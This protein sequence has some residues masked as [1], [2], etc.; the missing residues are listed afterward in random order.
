MKIVADENIALLGH[1]FGFLGTIIQ[2]AGRDI[3]A[4]DVRDADILLVRSVTKVDAAL[5]KNSTVKFVGSVTTGIDHLDVDWLNQANIVWKNA[6][7]CNANAVVEYII[8]VVASLQKEG[9]LL[10]DHLRAGIVGAG[11]IGSSVAEKLKM[12]GF[13]IVLCD[14]LQKNIVHTPFEHLEALD[15]ISFHTPFIQTGDYP[16]FHLV[17]KSFLQKQ[18]KD[19]VLVNTGRGAVFHSHDLKYYGREC[20]WCLD[21]WEN[22]PFIDFSLLEEA[23]IATPHI[24]GYSV[25]AKMRGTQMI[26]H[27]LM[28]WLN[29][30][31][32]I[33]LS[34]ENVL[35]IDCQNQLMDW[36][37]VVLKVF[38]PRKMTQQMQFIMPGGHNHFDWLRKN[39]T[40]RYEF[41]AVNFSHLNVSDADRGV[42]KQLKIIK[43]YMS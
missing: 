11:R 8:C 16:T 24:A 23:F 1:Y 19:C 43:S 27:A 17:D 10:K 35:K 34:E 25:Q 42:L 2:K 39:F 20:I 13:D 40:D 32:K 6:E 9:F 4:A 30:P 21:V 31:E 26:Y 28:Q 3:S 33:F 14:P 29:Q 15:F 12:L 5:L 37:D 36:R 18:K 41:S 7:G 22:E 38:D